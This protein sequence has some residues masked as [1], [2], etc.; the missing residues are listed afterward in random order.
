MFCAAHCLRDRRRLRPTTDLVGYRRPTLVPMPTPGNGP[1]TLVPMP[2]PGNGPPTLVPMT[3]PGNGPPTL[4]NEPQLTTIGAPT[5]D[6]NK[7]APAL[8]LTSPRSTL[9][10]TS[11]STRLTRRHIFDLRDETTICD[12][13]LRR[14]LQ[15][16]LA[17]L[18]Y[19]YVQHNYRLRRLL[20]TVSGSTVHDETTVC[21]N[22]DC[23]RRRLLFRLI[24]VW[25]PL[26]SAL[27]IGDRLVPT[28][29][30]GNGLLSGY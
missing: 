14:L 17:R 24:V 30:P 19:H 6:T 22:V 5:T 10:P 16:T 23:L 18:R 12:V 26:V 20:C 13:Y 4:G 25:F 21:D 3:T 27:D 15:T 9:T 1:L 8:A 28:P 2:T 7:T 11:A 29:T